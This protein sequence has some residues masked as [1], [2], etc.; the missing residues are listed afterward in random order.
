MKSLDAVEPSR[1][2][3]SHFPLSRD[4]NACKRPFVPVCAGERAGLCQSAPKWKMRDAQNLA[5]FREVTHYQVLTTMIRIPS[6]APICQPQN[7]RLT[8]TKGSIWGQLPA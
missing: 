8:S 6:L 4:A 2:S 1:L 5:V 7:Q 3:T